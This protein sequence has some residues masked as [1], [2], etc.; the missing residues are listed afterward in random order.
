MLA[1]RGGVMCIVVVQLCLS[2]VL[3][4]RL[5]PARLLCLWQFPGKN[6]GVD[7]HFLLHGNH[8]GSGIKPMPTA[9][10]SRFF[11]TEPPGKPKNIGVGSLSLP[12]GNFLTQELNQGPLYCR[13]IL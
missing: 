13:Q 9:L 3:P 8:P 10:A 7:F 12:Q 6:T 5:Y 2:F 11:A 1:Q 4:Y